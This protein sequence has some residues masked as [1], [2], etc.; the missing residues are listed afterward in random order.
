MSHFTVLVV[1]DVEAQLAPFDENDRSTFTPCTDA[2]MEKH[3]ADYATADHG[4]YSTFEHWME[5]WQGLKSR[6]G[7]F[8][9]TYNPRSKWDW[10]AVGGRWPNMLVTKAGVACDTALVGELD[11]ERMR[12]ARR[13]EAEKWWD[14][15]LKEDPRTREFLYRITPETTREQYLAT[16]DHGF[17]PFAVVLKKEWFE[18]GKMGWF[19][20]VSDAK[21]DEQ[22]REEFQKLL[23]S[24][25]ADARVTVVDC[26]I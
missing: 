20:S 24:L 22:W 3:R 19:A 26:H 17:V 16:R 18:K 8:G 4:E 5:A 7:V 1:G 21:P 11:F 14:E 15:S 9:T 25:P 6:D 12:A 23:V 13:A 2:E 10:Y